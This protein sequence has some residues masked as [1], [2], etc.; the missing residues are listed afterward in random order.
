[1]FVQPFIRIT[2]QAIDRVSENELQVEGSEVAQQISHFCR[3]FRGGLKLLLSKI[4]LENFKCFGAREFLL[5]NQFNLIVGANGSG[6]TALLDA[7]SVAI[8][9][10]LLGVDG[11]E[12]RHIRPHEIKLKRFPSGFVDSETPQIERYSWER[13]YPCSVSSNGT[14]SGQNLSWRRAVNSDG[15]R[16]TYG[17]ANDIKS[18]AIELVKKVREGE[19]IDLPVLSYYGTGRLWQEPRENFRVRGAKGTNKSQKRSRLDG[20]KTSVDPRLSVVQL[21]SWMAQEAWVAFQNRR[22]KTPEMEILNEAVRSCVDGVSDIYFDA[23]E[24]EI[25]V[26]IEGYAQ[27]FSNLSDGQRCMMALVGDIA[28]KA[29][30]LNPHQ[31]RKVL[32]LTGGVVMIDELDLHLHPRWQRNLIENLRSTFPSIQFICTTH[33]PF[34]IQSLR[35][36]EELLMLEGQPLD[37][38]NN[39][40]VEEISLEIQGVNQLEASVRYSQMK[41]EAKKV[42]VR[43]YDTEQLSD[44]EITALGEEVDDVVKKY[45]DNPAYQ[46]FLEM[47]KLSKLGGEK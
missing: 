43:L 19:V 8:G 46:A 12:S 39:R 41:D 38:L 3:L 37:K 47:E 13:Q 44:G 18:L 35:D 22:E 30:T 27:P 2:R 32:F 7:C 36:G 42:L 21:T 29:I 33:S 34:L 23:E 31:G 28:K 5:H 40:S 25:I 6:K 14:I 26:E 1:M 9:S 17:E 45:A 10:F 16:T 15:G 20:Y 11:A 4:T 24:G